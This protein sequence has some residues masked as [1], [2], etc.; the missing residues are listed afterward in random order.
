VGQIYAN[1]AELNEFHR[2]I[3]IFGCVNQ[4]C[5]NT[6]CIRVFREIVHERNKFLSI[7]TD[8]EYDEICD[9]SDDDLLC[10]GKW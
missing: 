5:I 1:V 6:Q 9:K 2:T 7:A 4:Q 3:Y 10:T 8:E